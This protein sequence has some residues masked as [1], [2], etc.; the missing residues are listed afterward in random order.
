MEE[1]CYEELDEGIREFV[2]ELN[3]AGFETTSSCEGGPGHAAPYPMVVIKA[4]I[5][6]LE[7]KALI[8][9]MQGRGIECTVS[10]HYL[11]QVNR[12]MPESFVKVELWKL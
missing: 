10:E 5:L 6:P 11:C 2:R 7:R 12:I 9:Y 4:D 1:I 8:L 3:E